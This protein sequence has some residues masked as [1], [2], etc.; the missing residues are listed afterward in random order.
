MHLVIRFSLIMIHK[1]L[2]WNQTRGKIRALHALN[3][4]SR[5]IKEPHTFEE[6]IDDIKAE[7]RSEIFEP[8][9]KWIYLKEDFFYDAFKTQERRNKD[10][11]LDLD[12]GVREKKEKREIL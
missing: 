3:I 9:F 2:M 7:H 11:R 1:S 5:N 4:K 12:N 6:N 10:L 8:Y